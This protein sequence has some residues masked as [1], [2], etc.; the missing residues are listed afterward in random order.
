MSLLTLL[1]HT[2]QLID[3]N[4]PLLAFHDAVGLG[5]ITTEGEHASII[6]EQG[7]LRVTSDV[8]HIELVLHGPF[9]AL[10]WLLQQRGSITHFPPGVQLLPRSS[11]HHHHLG[12]ILRTIDLN[13]DAV[14]HA[15]Q[16]AE[17]PHYFERPWR[18]PTMENPYLYRHYQSSPIPDYVPARL[19]RI[20]MDAHP[21]WVDMYDKAWQIAFRNL[22][23][24]EARSG[25]VANFI[26][27]AFND[28]SFLWDSC[29][30]TMFGRYARQAMDFMGTLDN[31]YAKQHVDGYIC[32]EISTY[33]GRDRWVP[34]EGRSTGP[35]I[36]AWTEWL[37]YQT[38]G[39]T[40]RLR[41]IFPALI[42]YH[43]WWQ[44]WRSYPDGSY[45]TT[46]LG[47]GM[48]NQMRVPDSAWHHR[49][50][51]WCDAMMQQALSCRILQKMGEVIGRREFNPSLQAEY[52]SIE[53]Y[54]NRHMWDDEAGF[55]FDRAP[56]GRL[57]DI[58]SIGAYWGLLSDL[59]PAERA[60]RMIAHLQDPA[61]FNRPH[62]VPSQSADSPDYFEDGHYWRGGVWAPTNYMV[63]RA[64]TEK[65][66]HEL[67]HEIARNHVGMIGR[68]FSETGTL[69]ENY[70]PEYAG[71]GNPA[72]PDFVGWT[73]ISAIAIPIEYLI[74]LRPQP[75]SN[76][77]E[78]D[79]RLEEQH[80]VENYPLASGN[81][82]AKFL[83]QPQ[84]AEPYIIVQS[85]LPIEL[86][87]HHAGQTRSYQIAASAPKQIRLNA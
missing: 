27:T 7:S 32:R 42:A 14:V 3:P 50:Y 39:N 8:K 44:D 18:Y 20:I 67:A 47:S 76:I 81:G 84:E 22:R 26:D 68:V 48:D 66:Q 71:I 85:D 25:F 37:N 73:G 34:H 80:A 12:Q 59:I 77:I 78:W 11:W 24:P 57:S 40:Q 36:I 1:E 79:I 56:D 31:F 15:V 87:V 33:D 72:R 23:Q 74:G 69:W 21:V 86:I 70:A 17:E 43:L 2:A 61:V 83:Y 75:N 29:F 54:L 13:M 30:M 49:H 6:F 58:K 55:Y 51:V 60:E 45:W 62:R 64:L 46:G 65:G 38:N 41:D 52:D 10:E 16:Q 4:S 19:P 63:L 9:K 28:N 35:N 82:Y 5:F 53:A